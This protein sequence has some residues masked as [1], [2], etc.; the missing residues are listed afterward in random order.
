MMLKSTS[1][2]FSSRAITASSSSW[3]RMR[4]PVRKIA[5]AIA[6]QNA[7][8]GRVQIGEALLFFSIGLCQESAEKTERRFFRHLPVRRDE[9][10][11]PEGAGRSLLAAAEERPANAPLV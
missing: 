11:A 6:R 10:A 8:D 2:S 5:L 4:A 9:E 3:R 1:V 7:K